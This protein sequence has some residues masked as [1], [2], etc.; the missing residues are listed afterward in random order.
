M[1]D[2]TVADTTSVQAKNAS[3]QT[4]PFVTVDTD[5]L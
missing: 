5:K 4:P 2:D 1:F 3:F